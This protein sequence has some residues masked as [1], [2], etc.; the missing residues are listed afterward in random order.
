MSA[1]Q[2]QIWFVDQLAPG[3]TAYNTARAFRLVG[4]LDTKSLEAAV[5]D[6][7][8]RH[9][10]LRTVFRE[11]GGEPVPLVLP[12]GG[13]RLT[14]CEVDTPS[15]VDRE[16]HALNI[17]TDHV[18]QPFD[19]AAGPLIRF[20]LIRLDAETHILAFVVHHICTDG[21]SMR[22]IVKDLADRYNAH[23]NGHKSQIE[24]PEVQF[25]DFADWQREKRGDNERDL[26]FWR[27]YLAD[28]QTLELT[29]DRRRPS[30]PTYRS[31][32]ISGSLSPE[33]T[34]AL[35][36]LAERSGASMLMI[37][38]TAFAAVLARHTRQSEIVLGTAAAGRPGPEFMDVI[39]PFINMLVLRND[40][41]G[42]P[43]F[44]ELL[45]RTKALLLQV[46]RRRHVPFEM[47]VAATRTER[48]ASRNPLFQVG[49]QLLERT[50]EPQFH[51]VETTWLGIDAGSHPLDLSI[52]AYETADGLQ[53]RVE[54][55]TD[56][57][58]RSRVHRL[59]S[60]LELVLRA[61]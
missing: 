28:L 33:L 49:I 54:F 24:P 5:A 61:A 38:T 56:L 7:V 60:H 8:E 6:V 31:S 32:L 42:D 22:F 2:R 57:F 1:A 23:L 19:L 48:D 3:L 29:T 40:V 44:T 55:A 11:V 43:T 13:Q 47:V 26:E 30:A 34:A 16:Q 17:V 41:S 59:M 51:G 14:T 39:G 27:D 45:D 9:E 46:W 10:I 50:P 58:D 12:P 36:L 37:L 21:W 25:A 20:V 52:S 18:R 4:A 15:V 53:F 35:H